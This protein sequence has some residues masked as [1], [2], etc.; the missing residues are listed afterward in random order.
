MAGHSRY[1]VSGLLAACLIAGGAGSPMAQGRGPVEEPT[2]GLVFQP[3]QGGC[4]DMGDLDVGVIEQVCVDDFLLARTEV[5]NAQFR[6]FRPEHRSGSFAGRSLDG[7]DQP[8]ANVSWRDAVAYAAW[9]GDRTGHR[10]RLPTEAEWEYAAR[11]G[12]R[13]A[14]F[15]GADED[16]AARYANLKERP[17]LPTDGHVV[18]APVGSLAPNPFGL[19][20]MLGNV[21]EWVEDAYLPGAD[22]Y[23]DR[24]RNP[25]V[26]GDGRLRVRRG[27]SFDDPPRIVRTSARDFYAADFAVPQTG[28]RLVMER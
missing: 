8:V 11:G 21:S 10:F 22:R 4:F 5:T 14:R 6:Q 19:H 17:G 16:D 1:W 23:G 15:W 12:T 20:D 26:E 2:S 7:D 24:R 28:F 3:I 18:T 27:G 9:L 13:T 25:K